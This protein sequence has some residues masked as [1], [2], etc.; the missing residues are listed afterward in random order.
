VLKEND[1]PTKELPMQ[2]KIRENAFCSDCSKDF[3]NFIAD[4][5][6]KWIDVETDYLFKNQYNVA[7]FRIMDKHISAVRDDARI[8]KG[9]CIYCGKF[10][11]AGET[12]TNHPHC[13]KY[14]IEWFTAENTA[15]I[16]HP[17]G[18]PSVKKISDD[19]PKFGSFR[20]EHLDGSLNYYRLKNAREKYCFLYVDGVFY[21]RDGSPK[22]HLGIKAMSFDE[23]KLKEYL[24]NQN[25]AI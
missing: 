1:Q 13:E 14:G 5:G 23:K 3:Q 16:A 24:E 12:C 2:I 17:N 25:K 21:M 6:G 11:S 15:F 10:V 4:N 9:K 7:K 18:F 19:E 20:L 22:K 8:G